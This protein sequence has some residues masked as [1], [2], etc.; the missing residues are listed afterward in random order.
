[1]NDKLNIDKQIKEKLEGL[2]IEPMPHV[3]NNLQEQMA[4]QKRKRR[5]AYAGWIAAAAVVVF[6]F[7]AG[8]LL[9][10]RSG[11]PMPQIVEQQTIQRQ[12]EENAEIKV[13]VADPEAIDSVN[14]NTE[15]DNSNSGADKTI[16][17]VSKEPGME[18]TFM[19]SIEK[20]SYDLLESLEAILW[21]EENNVML[22]EISLSRPLP[23]NEESTALSTID[24]D[25]VAANARNYQKGKDKGWIVGAHLSPGYS[26]QTTSHGDEYARNMSYSVDNGGSN[27]GGGVSLQYKTSK[28]LRVESG[29]YYSQNGQSSTNN[30]NRYLSVGKDVDYMYAVPENIAAD[31]PAFSNK[32]VLS[33]DGMAMNSS[34]G[35]V[36]LRSTPKGASVARNAEFENSDNSGILSTSG[37]FS[38][39]FEFVE[40]PLYLRY[41]VLDKRFGIEL[42]G[43]VNAGFV[44]GNK[45]YIDN[46]FG[47]QNIGS[48][49]DIS[50]LNFSGTVGLGLNYMLGKR[51]SL[52]VEPRLNYY[53]S[54]IN[55]NPAVDYR[56]Y[57]IGLFT[58]V[59]YEF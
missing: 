38:Q 24:A 30:L 22:A 8:W 18:N 12:A 33:S 14:N 34:A 55:S 10:E 1:M 23:E 50:T 27:I 47:K 7:I 28:R 26:S 35:V 45:A 44:V 51:F 42:L 37:E 3:W 15:E 4:V 36:N 49:E 25:I 46:E 2:S 53:L 48:T 29:I 6:A 43:G 13:A 20:I 59:Y 40:V 41:N 58:G 11:G 32:V 31:Q 52:A 9:N 57:R 16:S 39:V 56:P 19:A 54:S 17:S 21:Q 5:L